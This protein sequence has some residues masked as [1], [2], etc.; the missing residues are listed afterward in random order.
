MM[1]AF[2][3]ERLL[4]KGLRIYMSE[5]QYIQSIR[6]SGLH[7]TETYGGANFDVE[8]APGVNVM[9]GLNGSGK[10]TL[11]HIMANI[12]NLNFQKFVYL[13]FGEIAIRFT[14]GTRTQ[15][16]DIWTDSVGAKK[17]RM[18]H[19]DRE[20]LIVSGE[21]A[22]RM[23]QERT[24]PSHELSADHTFPTSMRAELQRFGRALNLQKEYARRAGQYIPDP[25][26]RTPEMDERYARLHNE[27]LQTTLPSVSYFPAFRNVSEIINLI[28]QNSTYHDSRFEASAV[29]QEIY[30]S[31]FGAFAPKFEYPS[32]LEIEFDLKD[33]VD[34]IVADVARQNR[35]VL[36]EISYK[37]LKASLPN[38]SEATTSLRSVVSDLQETP[39]YAWLPEVASTFNELFEEVTSD[40]T[41]MS[42]IAHLYSDALSE[43]VKEQRDKYEDIRLFKDDAVNR[44]LI[45]K[46]LVIQPGEDPRHQTE[47]GIRR[48]GT[49]ELIE[50]STM[51]SGERQVFSLLYAASFLGESEIVLIDEPEISLHIDWQTQLPEAMS[52]ILGKKQLVVCTHSPEIFSGFRKV[53]GA[54]TIELDPAPVEQYI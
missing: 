2:L 21:D 20:I 27:I 48:D 40:E 50:L 26:S 25:Y 24:N 32:L 17:C 53:K 47:V 29:A 39:I 10:T 18:P 46:E 14:D 16:V 5:Q 35:E 33:K 37:A 43:I 8:F 1:L 34:G 19:S 3:G 28:E 36:S 49:D 7:E 30:G 52:N 22:A 23:K 41:E 38:I 15:Y 44:F 12:L 11:M 13:D 31:A 9:Y 45:N 51:S 4:C 54:H 42:E 6:V